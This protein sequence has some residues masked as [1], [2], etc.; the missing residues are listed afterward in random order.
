MITRVVPMPIIIPPAP[1]QPTPPPGPLPGPPPR[2][3]KKNYLFIKFK[4]D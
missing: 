1:V 4:V 3:F 2:K